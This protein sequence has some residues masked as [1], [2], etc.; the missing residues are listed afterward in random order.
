MQFIKNDSSY[1]FDYVQV[2]LSSIDAANANHGVNRSALEGVPVPGIFER[3]AS[4]GCQDHCASLA[5][6]C[7]L[8]HCRQVGSLR[9]LELVELV[10]FLSHCVGF[11]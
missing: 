3:S 4:Y 11:Q 5:C 7:I 8:L 1:Y 2:C 6:S 10:A 9:G